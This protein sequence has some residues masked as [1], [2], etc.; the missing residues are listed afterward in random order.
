MPTEQALTLY[1]NNDEKLNFTITSNVVGFTLIGTDIEVYLKVARTTADN[2]P[3]VWV[4]TVDDGDVV[5]D[6]ADEGYVMIPR[7]AVT[8]TKGWYRIDVI[9]T[10]DIRKTAAYGTVTVVDL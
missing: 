5:I 6:D 10:G 7:S 2:D 8:T 3:G 4:G 9:D 1:E